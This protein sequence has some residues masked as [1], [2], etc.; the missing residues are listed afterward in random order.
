MSNFTANFLETRGTTFAEAFADTYGEDASLVIADF[1]NIITTIAHLARKKLSSPAG[2]MSFLAVVRENALFRDRPLTNVDI[3]DLGSGTDATAQYGEQILHRLLN[4]QAGTFVQTVKSGLHIRP[5]S[6]QQLLRLS[7]AL[8]CHTLASSIP[9]PIDSDTWQNPLEDDRVANPPFPPA[10]ASWISATGERS[11]ADRI[12]AMAKT[13]PK[14][15]HRIT[16]WILL[17]IASLLLLFLL[18]RGC[19][20]S[21]DVEDTGDSIIHEM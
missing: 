12:M 18:N 4:D 15:I 1:N 11:D 5:S 16:P 10:V 6:S 14:L 13:E 17:A 8:Y 19:A 20:A 2:T 3:L 9:E 7:T 21:T